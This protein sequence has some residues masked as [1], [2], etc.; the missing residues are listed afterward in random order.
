MFNINEAL[1][2]YNY[3]CALSLSFFTTDTVSSW[4]ERSKID[5]NEYEAECVRLETGCKES[6][7]S[8]YNIPV[9]LPADSD[10]VRYYIHVYIDKEHKF[11]G[12]PH[13][14]VPGFV[15]F[16]EKIEGITP[17]VAVIIPEDLI[18]LDIDTNSFEDIDYMYNQLQV[19]YSLLFDNIITA[20]SRYNAME[21]ADI[22]SCL[23][24]ST[25]TMFDI[26]KWTEY[27]IKIAEYNATKPDLKFLVSC[28]DEDR[29]K[30]KQ[31]FRLKC[32]IEEYK[33]FAEFVKD[34]REKHI[35]YTNPQIWYGDKFVEDFAKYMDYCTYRT[36]YRSY[37]IEET[38]GPDPIPV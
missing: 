9:R 11:S 3:F 15:K 30:A 35:F 7:G 23:Y 36:R 19:F 25:L 27:R 17:V 12:D 24:L 28:E 21:L 5:V 13:T 32:D 10:N 38:I 14:L 2:A 16:R 4:T 37:T 6:L 29:K 31:E 34:M 33:F 18:N 1:T 22:L 20:T 26:D 8:P